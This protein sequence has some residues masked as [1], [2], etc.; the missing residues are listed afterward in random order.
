MRERE[1]TKEREIDRRMAM[2][3]SPMV[4]NAMHGAAN[5]CRV[6]NDMSTK[7]PNSDERM[8]VTHEYKFPEGKDE[9]V[10]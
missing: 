7:K 3:G 6:G 10:I 5:C 9:R 1:R 4:G 8:D 2:Y